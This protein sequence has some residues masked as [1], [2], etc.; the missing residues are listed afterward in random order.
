MGEHGLESGVVDVDR[1]HPA[2]TG[3]SH[4]HCV[5]PDPTG[6][7]DHD[8]VPVGYVGSAHRL[9]RS[10]HRVGDHCEVGDVVVGRDLAES[11]H[12]ACRD[13]HVGCEAAVEVVPGHL[14]IAAHV[15]TTHGAHVT[16]PARDD[17]G[18]QHVLADP[19]VG[20]FAGLDDPAADLVTEDERQAGAGLNRPIDE[21]EVGVT[22]ATPRDFDDNLSRIGIAG[23]ALDPL[24]RQAGLDETP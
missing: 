21:S 22:E 17:G 20:A 16:A 24:Q 5:C 12:A 11:E 2:S 18:D 8:E 9:Q 14:L 6:A 4:L 10:G 3:C 7:D 13:G 15:A 19:C 23:R 1:D